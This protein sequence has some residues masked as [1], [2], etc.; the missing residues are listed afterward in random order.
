M[1]CSCLVYN[2]FNLWLILFSNLL[3]NYSTW[4][5]FFSSSIPSVYNFTIYL[6]NNPFYFILSTS[7]AL[8]SE[9]ISYNRPHLSK[10]FSDSL[11]LVTLA[12]ESPNSEINKFSITITIK[13]VDK[14]KKLQ[15]KY[16][17]LVCSLMILLN[18]S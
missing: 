15:T 4:V 7:A 18:W 17:W 9:S 8:N 1:S 14:K 11:A 13:K 2:S 10:L 16:G 5:P 12:K 3:I 6:P